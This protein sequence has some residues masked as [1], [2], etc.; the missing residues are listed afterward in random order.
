MLPPMRPRP[1]IPISMVIPSGAW[2]LDR[3]SNCCRQRLPTCSRLSAE[4]HPQHR[5]PARCERLQVAQR[6]RLLEDRKAVRLA[7]DGHVF[8][9]VLDDLQKKADL[10]AALV[11]LSGRV[12]EARPVARGGG[13]TGRISD[14]SSDPCYRD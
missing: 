1:T 8:R 2:L 6:L 3:C 12:E 13:V 4:R 11:Q 9:V 14:R 10:R 5:E 7:G